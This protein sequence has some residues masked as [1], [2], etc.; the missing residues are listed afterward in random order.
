MRTLIIGGTGLISVGIV[1]HL[2]ARGAQVAVFNRGKRDDTLPP[3]VERIIGDRDRSESFGPL[4]ANKRYDAVIDM[5]CFN[6]EQAQASIDAFGGRC[7]QFIFCST[8]ATYGVELPPRVLID[9]QFPQRPISEYGRNKVICEQA[10]LR[11]QQQGAFQTTIIRPSCTYGPG[12]TLIDQLEFAPTSW[13]RIER[14]LPVLCADGGMGLW[15]ATH[16]DDCGKAFAYA[17]MNPKTFG[18]AYNA[19]CDDIF[20]WRDFFREAA[21]GLGKKAMLVSMPADW[22]VERDP[23]RFGLLKDISR[24][25]APCDSSKAKRDIPEFRCEIGFRDGA[26]ETL[27]DVRK[28]GAWRDSRSDA[29]YQTMIDD[30]LAAGIRP[31]EA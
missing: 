15:Q 3:Q 29:L 2:L 13:D 19:T 21:A 12:G 8:V 5:M 22:I 28:R 1:K 27:S 10:F 31:F 20:T 4:F 17:V 30:A 25:H 7:Q 16:R 14:G 6:A 24:Y 23:Q 18:Q 26:R 11:A 9:E